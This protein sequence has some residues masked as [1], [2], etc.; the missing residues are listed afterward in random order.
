M[1]DLIKNLKY[2]D[3]FNKITIPD[4]NFMDVVEI[5]FIVLLIYMAVSH[6]RDTRAWTVIKGIL[7]LLVLYACAYLLSF[8]VVMSMFQALMG[9]IA[10]GVVI[11][12]Q[13]ELRK[14]LEGIGKRKLRIK[15]KEITKGYI[16]DKTIDAIVD[17]CL[18]MSPVRT[19]ALIVIRKDT[20]LNDYISTGITINADTSS[21][22]LQQ[23]F[24]HNTPLHDG[25]VIIENDRITAATCYL[26]LSENP[27]ISKELG[28]RHRAAIGM[29]EA[30]DCLVVIVSEET[31]SVSVAENGKISRG[32]SE[33]LFRKKLEAFQEKTVQQKTM[34]DT[35]KNLLF[36]NGKLKLLSVTVGIFIWLVFTNINNPAVIR[37][38]TGIPVKVENGNVFSESGKTY[39]ITDEC[40]AK[41]TVRG[42][43][44]ETESLSASDF[45]A[46]A[47]LSHISDINTV[48]ASIEAPPGIE[49]LENDN[50][51]R[52]SVE[53]I[54][55]IEQEITADTGT[56]KSV[57]IKDIDISPSSIRISGPVSVLNQIGEVRV[58][59][60]SGHVSD[61]YSEDLEPVIYDRN[62][63]VMNRQNLSLSSEH[64]RITYHT[65]PIRETWLDISI[66]NR[67]QK[68]GE[69]TD[70]SIYPE[71]IRIAASENMLQSLDRIRLRL[72]VT[73]PDDAGDS[74]MIREI[75]T[76]RY[77]PEGVFPA[78]RNKTV[79]IRF[80][81]KKYI[82]RTVEVPSSCIMIKGRERKKYRLP[83][84]TYQLTLTGIDS[85][86]RPLTGES[87]LLSVDCRKIKNGHTPLQVGNR[88]V[89]SFTAPRITITEK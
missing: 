44:S 60:T 16:S 74:N 47:D 42:K 25:A 48:S 89:R 22:L 15:K 73:V 58:R 12:F 21:Q 26:P 65:L 23:I 61:Q 77:L 10:V 71:T 82:T 69:I 80:T 35:C 55:T 40:V 62:G 1:S 39:S 66:K 59:G 57:Y 27:L 6:I 75:E 88:N 49:V 63:S 34:K 43:R 33:K 37:T 29:S 53:D 3:V 11:L 36:N 72:P 8:S 31:G 56:D 30:A 70:Y 54:A 17:A 41:V 51:Y 7:V 13:K 64:I 79:N 78:D 24:E 50:F 81:Y 45:K 68:N 87:L 85:Q 28:T 20:P 5:L 86:I 19:G 84:K 14:L 32:L 46:Y 83:E 2:N 67:R 76:A 52:V 38:I 18:E 4:I 9:V